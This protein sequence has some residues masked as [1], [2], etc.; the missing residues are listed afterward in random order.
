MTRHTGTIL[1]VD[2]NATNRLKLSMAVGHLGHSTRQAEHGRQALEV[3][4]EGGIDLMLLDILMPEMDGYQVLDVMKSDA[5]LRDIPVI[6]ISAVD[7]M[8]SVVACIERGAEDYL[9]KNFDPVLL[10]ARINAS[11]E[12]K[13][14][15]DAVME[16]MAFIRE[17]FGK[18][19]PD[20][21]ASALVR[22]RGV[23]EPVRTVATILYSDI[24]GFTGI[25]ENRPPEQTFEML[26]EYFP[27]VIEPI[28]RHGGI[29]NQI[30][31]D[32]ILALFNLPTENPRHADNAVQAAAEIMQ[33]TRERAFGGA[34]LTTRIGVSTGP[35][36]AGNVGDG[37]RLN[38]TALGDAVNIA[39]RLEQLNKEYGSNVLVSGETVDLLED[40]Y[41]L[42][43][44]GEV[45]IRG[46]REPVRVSILGPA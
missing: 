22:N 14:L 23:L 1:V 35:V 24:S 29:V 31:G 26:N 5:T 16:Q 38:Y 17:I 21:V 42:T 43:L 6:V 40:H 12:K 7:E 15:R 10:E 11:L 20:S 9:P 34:T 44:A 25:V 39:A 36:I 30:H 2:D 13:R 3:L 32:A 27:A 19:V 28:T 45:A 37:T 46:R 33:A 4:R 18:Y 41:P 8:A